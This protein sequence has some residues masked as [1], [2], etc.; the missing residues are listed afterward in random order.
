MIDRDN[1]LLKEIPRFH[2]LSRDYEQ[3]WVGEIRKCIEG[4]W[5]S[6]YWL[7]GRLY[8]YINFATMELSERNSKVRKL[9]QPR[10]RDT[11]WK[12]FNLW[13]E[14][15]GFSGF[16]GDENYSCHRLLIHPDYSDEDLKNQ[17]Y[18]STGQFLPRTY[19][20]FFKEDGTR[21]EYMPARDY[22]L[23]QFTKPMGKPNYF[24]EAQNLLVMGPRGW[25]KSYMAGNFAAH[26]WLFDGVTDYDEYLDNVRKHQEDDRVKLPK[27]NTIVG[28]GD[29]KYSTA[30]LS[31]TWMTITNLPGDQEVD[32]TLI[33]SP[34]AK[35]IK[36]S[37]QPG[38]EFMHFYKKKVGGTWKD[39][40]SKSVVKNRTFKDNP[41]A[42]QGERSS[43]MIWDEI[44]M[45][46]N[47]RESFAATDDVQRIDSY[48][49]GSSLFTGTGGDFE[50]EGTIDSNYMF[51]HPEEF[52]ILTFKDEWESNQSPIAFFLPSEYADEMFKN[53]KGITT[54][55][56]AARGRQYFV[57]QR[58]K[59]AGNKGDSLS[60]DNY[61][62]YHPLVPSEVFLSKLGNIFPVAELQHRI[63]TIKSEDIGS[64]MGKAVELYFDP[65]EL[66]GVNYKLDIN[67]KLD[68]IKEFPYNK[69]NR[70]GAVVIYEFPITDETGRV[71]EDLYL[72]GHDP[73]ASDNPDGSSLASI[74]VVKTKKHATKYDHDQIVAQ[75]VGRPFQGRKIVNEIL[76][77]LSMFYGDA[78]VY[79]ENAVGNVKEY[80]EKHKKLR[81]LSKTP[82]TVLTKKASFVQ[83]APLTYGYPMSNKAIK[84]EAL[85]YL[86]DWL[87][88]ER[89][90]DES[91]R[92]LRNLDTIWDL[93]LL[94]ELIQFNFEGNFDRVMGLAGAIIGLEESYNQYKEAL[95]E[96]KKAMSLDFLTNNSKMFRNVEVKDNFLNRL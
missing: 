87:L 65:H 92:I 51:Y 10:M 44:G 35:Q 5:E 79:F 80:F 4:K 37:I 59:K 19:A 81:L 58:K 84:M 23:Q 21:K 41:F 39:M 40:G 82:T 38:K 42:A 16:E 26:E 50:G 47:L 22:L 66:H 20:N 86:R 29:A 67:R 11:E 83:N 77:K 13:E 48:K 91:G 2:P 53:E 46:N 30:T 94:Q 70:E 8:F 33:P 52:D 49:F 63:N 85:N 7:P 72:I 57:E 25:G 32:G 74:Y 24:N 96:D 17:C 34:L 36:G 68:P 3:F 61:I 12:V 64:Y 14:A 45:F 31:K 75:Y 18:T 73:Y 55:E 28:A 62:V 15:R 93:A 54:P 78:T 60:L 9:G 27:T 43:C 1:Y 69:S 76:M 71:P 89:G 6:G 95:V 90:V 56:L 88:D